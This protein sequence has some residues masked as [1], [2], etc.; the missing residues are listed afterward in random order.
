MHQQKEELP[1]TPEGGGVSVGLVGW[2]GTAISFMQ[3]PAG[4]DLTPAL[5]GMPDDLRQCPH[6]GYVL[7]GAVHVRYTDG[8]EETVEAGDVYYWPPGHTV[9]FDEDTK[10]VEFSPEGGMG[11]VL[12]HVERQS[13]G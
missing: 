2:D 3:M 6:W 9:W 7:E 13:E 11:E 8:E 1:V 4:S 12:D 5:K 10:F